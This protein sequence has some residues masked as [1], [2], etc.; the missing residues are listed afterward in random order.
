MQSEFVH[1][2]AI[3]ATALYQVIS[4]TSARLKGPPREHQEGQEEM[5]YQ[6]ENKIKAWDKTVVEEMNKAKLHS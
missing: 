4:R 2:M 3:F 6:K 5:G 1:K